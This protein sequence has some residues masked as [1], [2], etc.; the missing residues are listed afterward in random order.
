MEILK[1]ALASWSWVV[2]CVLVI[3]LGRIAYFYEKTSG[4]RVGYYLF[5]LPPIFLI[6]G[7]FLYL[8]SDVDFVGYPTADMLLACGGGLLIYLSIHLESSMTGKRS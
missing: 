1:L 7:A 3:F 8:V 2:I 5:V 6:V 4:H